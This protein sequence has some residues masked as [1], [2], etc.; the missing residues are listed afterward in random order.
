MTRSGPRQLILL[1]GRFTMVGGMITVRG[2][3]LPTGA[4]LQTHERFASELSIGFQCV[5]RSAVWP[6]C[7]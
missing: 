3:G 5:T 2:C 7:R 1:S 6:N 4:L